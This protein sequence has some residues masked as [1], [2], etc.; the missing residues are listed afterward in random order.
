MMKIA[1][2]GAG[3]M[4]SRFGKM[5]QDADQDVTLIDNWAAHVTQIQ[6]RGL[7]FHLPEGDATVAFPAFTPAALK[8][9]HFDLIILFTK[10][11]QM[12]GMLEDIQGVIDQ[13]TKILVLANGIG[14]VE[15]IERFVPRKQIIAGVTVW[16]AELDGPGEVTLT[17]TGS[18][19]LQAV[20]PDAANDAFLT[21]LVAVMN[22]AH[23]N[24]TVS[25][26]VI[27]AI[28]KK[29]A[30][31]SVLNTYTSLISC[32]VG[33][34]GRFSH[35]DALITAT[36]HEI[37]QVAAGLKVP[38]DEPATLALIMSQFAPGQN[39]AHYASMYQDLAK[40]RLTEIDYLNGYVA[41]KGAELG[42]PTPINNTLTALI[43]CREELNQMQAK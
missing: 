3:A 26:S 40:H 7:L 19:S 16:S 11:M 33:E 34:F 22:Q 27:E 35:R 13:D 12:A 14:N 42:I 10:A 6:Q 23:L 4:G 24:V 15:T 36:L 1:I 28:W 29:A 31:N 41:K 25:P 17:G 37:A 20:A 39:G 38:F 8:P 2:A 43:H 5:L 30:F 18:V 9:Q 32:N 21:Q